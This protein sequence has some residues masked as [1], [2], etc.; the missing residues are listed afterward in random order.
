MT[1]YA[2]YQML[3]MDSQARFPYFVEIRN[4]DLGVFR[5]VNLDEDKVFMG[6]TYTASWFTVTPP[7]RNESSISNAKITISSVD[8]EWIQRIR[9]TQKRSTIRFVAAIDYEQGGGEVIE[10]LADNMFV[11]TSASWDDLTITW[12]MVFDE[13]MSIMIPCDIAGPLNVPGCS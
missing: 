8:Q 12:D 10:P 13:N 1:A 3:R 9:S 5:Y 4:E 6:D 7:E 2:K 11:L